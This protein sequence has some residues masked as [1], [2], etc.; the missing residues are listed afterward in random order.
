MLATSESTDQLHTE[1]P[2]FEERTYLL[3]AR[4]RAKRDRDMSLYEFDSYSEDKLKT[5]EEHTGNVRE[6]YGCQFFNVRRYHN[7]ES[8]PYRELATPWL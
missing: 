5:G 2:S 4:P 3:E 8:R 1:P 6:A 7:V